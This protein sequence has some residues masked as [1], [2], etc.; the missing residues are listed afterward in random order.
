MNKEVKSKS[1]DE[2]FLEQKMKQLKAIST[3]PRLAWRE[4]FEIKDP[5]TGRKYFALLQIRDAEHTF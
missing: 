2:M 5:E 4:I 1:L 3:D